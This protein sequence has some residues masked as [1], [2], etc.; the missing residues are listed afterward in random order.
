MRVGVRFLV[1]MVKVRGYSVC[2]GESSESSALPSNPT[3]LHLVSIVYRY[4]PVS[5][6]MLGSFDHLRN[7]EVLSVMGNR[8]FKV[9][10][11]RFF[12]Q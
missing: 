4:N 5:V 9:Y 2:L 12:W 10:V 1:G 7:K 11:L 3:Q 8:S 6:L